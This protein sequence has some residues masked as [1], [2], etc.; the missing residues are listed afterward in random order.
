MLKIN[1]RDDQLISDDIRRIIINYAPT[2]NDRFHIMF[3]VKDGVIELSGYVR[4]RPTAAYLIDRVRQ[5]EGVLGLET[6]HFYS[7]EGL[8]LEIG[9]IIPS[10]V[11]VRVEY[12]TVILAGRP[13]DDVDSEIILQSVS[14]VAGV[15]RVINAMG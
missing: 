9:R 10:G 8:R 4:T 7:D 1:Q 13:I 2:A 5:I 6:D 14:Q 3:H 11:Q 12:G 15:Q